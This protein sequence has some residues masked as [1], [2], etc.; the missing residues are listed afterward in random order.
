MQLTELTTQMLKN[1][2]GIN[3]NMVIHSGNKISTMSE[4]RNILSSCTVDMT[5]EQTIGL[6]D[7]NEFLGV[8]GLVDEP[9]LTFEEKM[10][11]I[12]DSTGRSKIQYYLTDIDH[13]T[14]PD[15]AMIDKANSMNDFEVKFTLDNETLNKIR[16]A[17]STLGHETISITGSS[18]A[19]KLTV[20]DPENKTSNTFSIE[21]AG[22]YES[23]DFNFLMNI[24]NVKIVGGDYNVGVSSKL[25]S[26]FK[27][28]ESDIQYWIALEKA[29]TYGV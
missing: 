22:E 7:L 3:S 6:Y 17:A 16:R 11:N 21:V 28:T 19:I 15:T 13:L 8:V 20:C 26:S 1:Y 10:V 4:A 29:S 12:G 18:G 9:H 27:H 24:N 25:L 5:F 14:S 23:E 2:S